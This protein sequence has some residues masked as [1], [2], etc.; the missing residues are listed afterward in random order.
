MS[1]FAE[2]QAYKEKHGC[3]DCKIKYPHYV[4]EFDHRPENKKIDVVYR[5]LRRLGREAAWKEVNKCDV[6]CANCHKQRTYERE[7]RVSRR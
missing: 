4:L 1:V 6:V 5:V 7:Q 3:E 2:F